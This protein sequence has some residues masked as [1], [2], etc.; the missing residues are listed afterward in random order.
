MEPSVQRVKADFDRDG[1][2][3]IR[4]FL[5]PE[6][7]AEMEERTAYYIEHLLPHMPPKAAFYEDRDDPAS[8]FRLE[9]LDVR[10]AWADRMVHSERMMELAALLLE[11]TP[12]PQG[13]SMFGKAPR[14]GKETPAHQDGYYFMLEPNEAITI[15]LPMDVVDETNGCI[16]YVKGS[17]KRGLRPHG[18]SKVFGFSQGVEDYGPGDAEVEVAIRAD[19]GDL[20][21]HHSM[22]IHRADPNRSDQRRWAI[23]LV[24]YAERARQD[25]VAR[26]AYDAKLKKEWAAAGKL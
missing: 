19:P 10:F 11:D 23:G 5:S 1:F 18:R 24:Y 7:V 22:T 4:G 2:A 9:K 15:W 17:H 8:L 26:E 21:V 12:V 20:I 14:I 13:C 16:R 25:V 6:Q 3:A